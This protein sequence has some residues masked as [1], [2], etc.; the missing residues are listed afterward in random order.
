MSARRS[1]RRD[2]LR[3]QSAVDAVNDLLDAVPPSLDVAPIESGGRYLLTLR[4]R[5]MAC[6][7]VAMFNAGQYDAAPV[8]AIE[9]LN[10]IEALEAQLTVY[11]DTSEVQAI[12][13]DAAA[14]PVEVEERLFDLI[15]L[16][17][18]IH[19][20]T[21]GAYDVTAGPLSKAWGFFRRQGEVPDEAALAEALAKVGTAKLQLEPDARTVAFTQSGVELNFGGIGKGYALDR[22]AECLTSGGIGD[23]LL[24]GGNSS[25]L[26]RGARASGNPDDRGWRISLGDPLRPGKTLLDFALVDRAA[27]TSG[28]QYQFFRSAGKRYGHVIDPR[29]GY[30]AEQVVCATVLAPTAAVAD[31]L[32]TALFI[33]GP[34]EAERYCAVHHEI[35]AALLCPGR[36]P[37]QPELWRFNWDAADDPLAS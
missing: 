34:E 28:T 25:I 29:T 21:H 11:R 36:Q 14:G 24:H 35:S 2:F 3:G 22:A 6:D 7:F 20:E 15:A 18:R 5:A 10:L 31:A 1:S 19:A 13:R 33:L 32:S 23:F 9:A 37:N 26:A 8:L 30:P 12:N 27:G 17:V 16:A 4:R